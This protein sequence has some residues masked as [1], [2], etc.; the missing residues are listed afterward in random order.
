M[1]LQIL[2][3]YINNTNRFGVLSVRIVHVR[4]HW[5]SIISLVCG[6]GHRCVAFCMIVMFTYPL[7]HG[8][9]FSASLDCSLELLHAASHTFFLGTNAK[10][11][12]EMG[13]ITVCLTSVCYC[14]A[15]QNSRDR[16][17]ATEKH[18]KSIFR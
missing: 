4:V 15:S 16:D 2:G 1:T 6:C 14:P 9:V 13:F 8:P 12:K 5:R 3:I 17:T 10:T 11:E 18:H 7:C